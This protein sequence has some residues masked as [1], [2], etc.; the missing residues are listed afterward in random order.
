MGLDVIKYIIGI[1]VLFILFEKERMI[2]NDK[3]F[4]ESYNHCRYSR[5]DRLQ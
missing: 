5:H 2:K 1:A 3:E 4:S